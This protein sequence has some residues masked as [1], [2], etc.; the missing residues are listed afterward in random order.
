MKTK[1]A[2]GETKREK[3]KG[4]FLDP[5]RVKPFKDQPRKRFRGI[6]K[7]AASIRRIGQVTTPSS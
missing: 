5:F 6:A 2:G 4:T 1:L 3:A 7:L